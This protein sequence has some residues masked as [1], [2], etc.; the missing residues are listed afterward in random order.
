MKTFEEWIILAN[1]IFNGK[2]EYVRQYKKDN[3]YQFLEIKC[4]IHGTFH[5]KIQTI[6]KRNKDVQNVQNLVN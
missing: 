4:D 2:Y 1:E 6:L 5:K 3:K